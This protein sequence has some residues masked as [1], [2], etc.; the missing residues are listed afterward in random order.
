MELAAP[1][2]F[3]AAVFLAGEIRIKSV[4][5]NIFPGLVGLKMSGKKNIPLLLVDP[6]S[7]VY[8][9][10][11]NMSLAY[12]ATLYNSV[13]VDQ[14][15]LPYPRNR[16][17]KYEAETLAISVRSFAYGEARKVAE[18]YQQKYPRTSSK[19]FLAIFTAVSICCRVS[20]L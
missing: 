8:I 19:Y 12:A 1:S 13:V 2:G 5:P 6:Y 15:I 14:H 17:L 11:P 10:L 3:F 18:K 4:F 9:N 7:E 16:F 20:P